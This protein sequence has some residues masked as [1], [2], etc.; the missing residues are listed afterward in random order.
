MTTLKKWFKKSLSSFLQ[1]PAHQFSCNEGEKK[2]S[3]NF[4]KGKEKATDFLVWF[5]LVDPAVHATN[6]HPIL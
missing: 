5:A 4:N 3:L 1:Q 6:P 2:I